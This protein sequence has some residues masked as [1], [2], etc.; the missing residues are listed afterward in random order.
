MNPDEIDRI[1]ANFR[2]WLEALPDPAEPRPTAPPAVDFGA[3]ASQFTALRHDVNLQTKATRAVLD[4]SGEALKQLAA[5]PATADPESHLQPTRKLL[6]DLADAL[7]LSLKQVQRTLESH[8][9]AV[10]NS[11]PEPAQPRWTL[12]QR[13]TG[14]AG[15]SA[16]WRAWVGAM[17]SHANGMAEARRAEREHQNSI[18]AGLA[19]GYALSLRRIERAFP[20]FDLEPIECDGEAFDPE[21]M[22]VVEVIG[23]SDAASGTVVNV[24]RAGYRV[25]GRVF[26]FAQ[27]A[28]AR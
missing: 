25:N 27:V 18:L 13:L 11:V 10:E 28:V 6:V 9:E 14:V 26:R 19:D 5:R 4:Q 12:W 15:P 1:L 24:V 2:T 7:N 20:Q 23:D 8:A 16:E 21:L 17:R 22:E 3:L